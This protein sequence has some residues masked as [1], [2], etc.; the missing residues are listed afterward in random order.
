MKV[1][2]MCIYVYSLLC[3]IP[4]EYLAF[5]LFN[6]HKCLALWIGLNF[7]GTK[8][9]GLSQ[10]RSTIG[11]HFVRGTSQNN[12]LKIAWQL[13]FGAQIQTHSMCLVRVFGRQTKS[14]ISWGYDCVANCLFSVL[15]LYSRHTK[16]T[17][18]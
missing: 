2:K 12:F 14:F 7:A 13:V 5:D 11:K 4:T 18:I 17:H 6:P 10:L 1:P 9:Q 8:W 3:C 15:L 16:T